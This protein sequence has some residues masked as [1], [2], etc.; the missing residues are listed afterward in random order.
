MRPN[1]V[2]KYIGMVLLLDA[3][4]M[5]AAAFVSL[6]C[7]A[8]S[9]FW[10]LLLSSALTA[11]LGLFPVIFVPSERQVSNKEGYCIVVGAWLA[12]CVVGM[13]PYLLWSGGGEFTLEKAWFESVSGFTTTGSTIL[14]DVEALPHGLLFWR[15]CTHWIGGVGVVMFAMLIMPVLGRSRMMVSSVEMS[16]ISHDDYKYTSG[17]IIRILLTVYIG[18]TTACFVMLKVAGMGWFD[19]VNHAMSTIATGGFSTRNLSIAYWNSPLIETVTMIF[20]AVAGIH[21]GVIFATLT[22]RRN[23]VFRSE[24]VRYWVVCLVVATL[25]IATGTT[26]NGTY[27]SWWQALRFSSFQ[28]VATATT[29]GFV[30]ADTTVWGSLAMVVLMFMGIQCACA[31]S[32]SGGMKADRVWLAAKIMHRQIRQQQHPNAVIRIKLG[33][34]T[35][36]PSTLGFVMLFIVA[37][38]LLMGLGTLFIAAFGYDLTKSFSMSLSS[39]GN[40]GPGFGEVGGFHNFASLPTGVRLVCTL[41]M[42][43][44]RLEI[45]GLLQLFLLKWW[46]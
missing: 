4:F 12:S 33:G 35:Q 6:M 36:E 13:L 7:G 11:V 1:V 16:S 43:L 25:V 26:L 45:F 24:V 27:D 38:F 29:T 15:S 3:A 37:Y 2:Y 23:N 32:T 17:K 14:A 22:G 8:G 18:L 41:L 30:A 42:L 34:V 39:L 46:R 9:S 10:S 19:A 31:G 5:L 20:M 21:F 40:V 44:G 28:T